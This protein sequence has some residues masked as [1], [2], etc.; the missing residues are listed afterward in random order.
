M[1][2][3]TQHTQCQ[4]AETRTTRTHTHTHTHTQRERI[5]NINGVKKNINNPPVIV[6]RVNT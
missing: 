1:Y 5:F 2:I 3:H 6:E 4:N